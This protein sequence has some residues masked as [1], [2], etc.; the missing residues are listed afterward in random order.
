MAREIRDPFI[1]GYYDTPADAEAAKS[2][3]CFDTVVVLGDHPEVW[4]VPA[5]V[6]DVFLAAGYE[7]A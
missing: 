6:V 2:L 7:P 3:W 1:L 5:S 4:L